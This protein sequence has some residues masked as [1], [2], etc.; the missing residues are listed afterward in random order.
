MPNR[1]ALIA[2]IKAIFILVDD[3]VTRFKRILP[4]TGLPQRPEVLERT[5][6]LCKGELHATLG[7]NACSSSHQ[8]DLVC[9]TS[10]ALLSVI[11]P[12]KCEYLFKVQT[13]AVCIVD[14]EG[15]AKDEL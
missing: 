3:G 15:K 10:N 14:E 5:R 1:T 9:G 2:V 6:S 13:P 11:E 8:V 12:E 4:K 7:S